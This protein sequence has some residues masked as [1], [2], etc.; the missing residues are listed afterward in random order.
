M[1]KVT[2]RAAVK[3]ARS[4]MRVPPA[5]SV[6]AAVGRPVGAQNEEAGAAVSGQLRQLLLRRRVG[7]QPPRTGKNLSLIYRSSVHKRRC[8]KHPFG[9]VLVSACRLA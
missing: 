7:S 6:V 1:T 3:P 5:R 9:C 8:K 4:V 2:E